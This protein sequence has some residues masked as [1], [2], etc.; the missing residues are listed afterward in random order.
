M[1]ALGSEG[2]P[3]AR[4]AFSIQ[5]SAVVTWLAGNVLTFVSSLIPRHARPAR[6]VL[7]GDVLSCVNCTSQV[8]TGHR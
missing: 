5:F 1:R 4:S 3:S 7:P 2:S 8:V 6:L